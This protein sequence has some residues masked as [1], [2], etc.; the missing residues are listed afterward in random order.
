MSNDIVTALRAM[1]SGDFREAPRIYVSADQAADE[2]ER[3]RADRDN[4]FGIAEQLFENAYHDAHCRFTNTM[5]CSCGLMASLNKFIEAD[6]LKD[7][8]W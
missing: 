5:Q 8:A 3:L 6:L 2:I 4:W 1:N 7:G